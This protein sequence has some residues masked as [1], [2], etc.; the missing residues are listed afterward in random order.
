MKIGRVTF[1]KDDFGYGMAYILWKNGIESKRAGI[2]TAREFDV[3]LFSIFWWAHVYKFYAF[4]HKVKVG[5]KREIPHIIVGGFNAFNPNV[6]FPF[7]H[8]EGMEKYTEAPREKPWKIV[9]I[10]NNVNT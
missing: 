6:F 8:Q 9:K 7:A 4:C 1:G 3:L 2:K 10:K 5:G